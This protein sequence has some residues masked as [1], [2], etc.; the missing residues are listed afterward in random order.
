MYSPSYP[1]QRRLRYLRSLPLEPVEYCQRWVKS[2][3]AKGYRKVCINALAEA[4]GLSNGTVGNWGAA[5]ERRPHYILHVLRQVD[6]LNQ[7][8]QLEQSGQ[9]NLSSDWLRE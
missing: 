1:N 5:F 7:I 4:T 6:L 8:E 9:V 2:D 3:P